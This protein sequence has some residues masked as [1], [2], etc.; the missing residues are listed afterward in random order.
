MG[1]SADP[2]QP[3]QVE[4][5]NHLL[6]FQ[7]IPVT[8]TSVWSA[9]VKRTVLAPFPPTDHSCSICWWWYSSKTLSALLLSLSLPSLNRCWT[10]P[11]EQ[12]SAGGALA[13]HTACSRLAQLLAIPMCRPAWE[14]YR[15]RPG[16]S[17]ADYQ[18]RVQ[19]PFSFHAKHALRDEIS[20]EQSILRTR[21]L[22][23]CQDTGELHWAS[24]PRASKSP[25]ARIMHGRKQLC[26]GLPA[27]LSFC[28]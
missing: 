19:D 2:P 4:C 17:A 25:I 9:Q 27:Y 15:Q 13:C 20:L 26:V 14:E 8:W 7:L 12:D 23:R 3:V 1:I 5:L 28:L 16:E 22:Q 11:A 10:S 6:V 24:L 18:Y 21:R